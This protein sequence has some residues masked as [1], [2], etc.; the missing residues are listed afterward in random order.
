MNIPD[1][2]VTMVLTPLDTGTEALFA[3]LP[4]G[5]LQSRGKKSAKGVENTLTEDQPVRSDYAPLSTP[6]LR[7]KGITSL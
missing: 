3:I 4:A 6:N 7:D 2:V 5:S 1:T